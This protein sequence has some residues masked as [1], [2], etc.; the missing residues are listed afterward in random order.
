L[1]RTEL[2]AGHHGPSGRYSAWREEAFVVAFVLDAV[3]IFFLL[4]P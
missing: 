2:E 4:R 1:L 3:G